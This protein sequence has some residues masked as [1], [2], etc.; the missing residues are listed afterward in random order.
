MRIAAC[1]EMAELIH[2]LTRTLNEKKVPTGATEEEIA[3][4]YIVLQQLIL[5][6][7]KTDAAFFK[8]LKKKLN[9]L[10]KKFVA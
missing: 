7:F 9:K 2:C 3:D 10:E 8:V 6:Y 4:V 1:E 5:M